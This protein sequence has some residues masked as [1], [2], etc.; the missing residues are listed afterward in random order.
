MAM[1]FNEYAKQNGASILLMD[2]D[3]KLEKVAGDEVV[4]YGSVYGSPFKE[5][6]DSAFTS[7]PGY[8]T[9]CWKTTGM[10]PAKRNPAV[11][12][13]YIRPRMI[14][15]VVREPLT[16]LEDGSVIGDMVL[17]V[18]LYHYVSGK[19]RNFDCDEE[20]KELTRSEWCFV[21]T[22]PEST[23]GPEFFLKITG[24]AERL[25]DLSRQGHTEVRFERKPVCKWLAKNGR[26]CGREASP[27]R[28]RSTY[29][30]PVTLIEG[31]GEHARNS[32][33]G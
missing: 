4:F 10:M 22:R 19:A 26:Q 14:E 31:W 20:N 32:G 17:S 18:L 27:N 5:I 25:T 15:A 16:G 3:L 7:E 11:F 12:D 13:Q 6:P 33:R 8:R 24:L 2:E 9:W 23:C 1:N 30:I 21:E 28:V 29:A